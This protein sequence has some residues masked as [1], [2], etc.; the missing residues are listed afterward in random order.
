MYQS[1]SEEGATFYIV[2]V[3]SVVGGAPKRLPG[4]R[5]PTPGTRRPSPGARRPAPVKPHLTR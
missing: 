3:G 1:S 4:T 2:G 5:R